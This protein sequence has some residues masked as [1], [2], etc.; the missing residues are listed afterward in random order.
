M[1]DKPITYK[2]DCRYL[3]SHEWARQEGD[4]IVI[5]VSDCAQNQLGDVVFVELPAIGKEVTAGKAFGVIESV[6][7]ASDLNAPVS[8]KVVAINETLANDPARVN[9]DAFGGG[10]MIKV[11]PSNPAELAKLLDAATYQKKIEAG[12]LH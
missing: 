4:L 5:G 2:T 9:Q 12:E 6:K 8:G 11:K 3:E 1:S 7:A 10:W